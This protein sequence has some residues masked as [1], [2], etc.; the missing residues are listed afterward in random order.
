MWSGLPWGEEASS[1]KRKPVTSGLR[2]Y[3]SRIQTSLPLMN[4]HPEVANSLLRQLL[5]EGLF[6]SLLGLC[7]FRNKCC[8]GQA[9][10]LAAFPPHFTQTELTEVKGSGFQHPGYHCGL[11]TK[12]WLFSSAQKERTVSWDWSIT[13]ERQGQFA[14]PPG[15]GASSFLPAF[16]ATICQYTISWFFPNPSSCF[17][18]YFPL[19]CYRFSLQYLQLPFSAL[20]PPFLPICDPYY[21]LVSLSFVSGD[22]K[23]CS[24]KSRV[25]V[26]DAFSLI[27]LPVAVER[28]GPTPSSLELRIPTT[29]IASDLTTSQLPTSSLIQKTPFFLQVWACSHTTDRPESKTAGNTSLEVVRAGSVGL[30]LSAKHLLVNQINYAINLD[31]RI[32]ER[33]PGDFLH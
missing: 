21:Y 13:F 4:Q 23:N 3:E 24:S 18:S 22:R 32:W 14:W 5:L 6:T 31:L 20:S 27:Y 29:S 19:P 10:V 8:S 7:L 33:R 17:S 16:A 12:Q 25:Q 26:Y 15:K 11:L 2:V 1:S 28:G 30:P 9:L